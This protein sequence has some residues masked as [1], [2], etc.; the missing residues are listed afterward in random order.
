MQDSK[1]TLS[2]QELQLAGDQSFFLQKKIIT[3]KIIAVL[4][5]LNHE[6]ELIKSVHAASLPR[7]VLK[8]SGKI[9]KGENYLGLPYIVSDNPRVFSKQDIFAYRSM[10]WWGNYFSFTLHL[11]GKFMDDYRQNFLNRFHQLQ[12]KN[13]LICI[14]SEQWI[15]HLEKENYQPLDG[16]TKKQLA[17]LLNENKFLK[18][19][20]KLSLKQ[21]KNTVNFGA[22]TFGDYL[23]AL[24]L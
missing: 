9:S 18:L 7:D 20:R 14:H 19:S 17:N 8:I 1:F 5:E 23:A 4:H 15:H 21:F 16:F 10:F 3:Q 6:I 13:Y 2:A 22:E 11:S 24:V 12:K